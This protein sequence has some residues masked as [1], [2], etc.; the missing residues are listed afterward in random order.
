MAPP[1]NGQGR[2][3]HLARLRKVEALRCLARA[4]RTP[5]QVAL[6]FVLAQAGVT[7][8]IPGAKSPGQARANA[9]AADLALSEADWKQARDLTA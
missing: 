9:A 3:D 4:G 2:S 1:R 8:A 6:A 5:A 7:V